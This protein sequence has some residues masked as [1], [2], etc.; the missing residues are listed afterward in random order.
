MA[1]DIP[2]LTVSQL[3]DALDAGVLLIDL[4]PH[5]QFASSHIPGSINVV[6]SRK[7]LPERIATAIPQGSPFVLLSED[8]HITGAAVEALARTDRNHLYGTVSEGVRMW[9]SAGLSPATLT[10]LPVP[11]LWQH[12][13]AGR[14]E[15]L[16]I[17]VREPFEWEWGYIEG[18][19]LIS[20]GEI[21]QRAGSLDPHKDTVLICQEGLRS[22]TAASIL[23][24]HKFPRIRNVAGG[25][26]NW[27]NATYPT[28]R[29]SKR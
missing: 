6:F 1:F 11:L 28:V 4:R 15:L 29:P 25:M 14:N 26:G 22:S 20:L 12:L 10:Q 17:D 3:R 9:C 16:L 5:E 21:W 18:A 2:Q 24:H 13:N 8:E 27:L 7:S 19:L 23:L